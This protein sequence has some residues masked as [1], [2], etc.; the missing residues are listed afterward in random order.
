LSERD[1]QIEVELESGAGRLLGRK[2]FPRQ[3]SCDELASA[4][5]VAIA[6]WE[7]ALT[8]SAPEVAIET[9]PSLAAPARER[10]ITFAIGGGPMAT[11]NSG[12]W[13]IGGEA[14]LLVALADTRWSGRFSAF[15][16]TA[17]SDML[18]SGDVAWARHG[19]GVGGRYRVA[20]WEALAFDV[21][22][23]AMFGVFRAS[24]DGFAVDRKSASFEPGLGGGVS[25][26]LDLGWWAA[27][28]EI[29]EMVWLVDRQ[30]EVTG[31]QTRVDLPRHEVHLNVG[32]V[33][34]FAKL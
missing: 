12:G 26:T 33:V 27:V 17:R 24:G 13:A 6:T 7:A 21:A 25:T 32:L 4:I 20:A 14:Q 16:P 5:A 22:G 30:I 15:P 10:S 9:S 3:T 11:Y 28:V 18:A 19:I 23:D 29:G 8:G 1:D 34:G 31:A 2:V